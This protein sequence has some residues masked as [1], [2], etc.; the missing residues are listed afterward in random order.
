[1]E[2]VSTIENF[3]EPDGFFGQSDVY[4]KGFKHWGHEGTRR[5]TLGLGWLSFAI[6]RVPGGL[7]FWCFLGFLAAE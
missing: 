5:K 1:M 6:L 4:G 3:D 2:V 7:Q